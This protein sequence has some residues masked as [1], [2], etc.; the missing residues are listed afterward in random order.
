M[1]KLGVRDAIIAVVL[2]AV[3]AAATVV[4]ALAESGSSGASSQPP[5]KA[6]QAAGPAACAT[7][8]PSGPLQETPTKTPPPPT[9]TA[10][11]TKTPLPTQTAGPTKTPTNTP[12]NT[13]TDTPTNTPT[14]TPTNTPTDTPTNTPTDT[15][16]NTPTD[17][18]TNTPT[19]TPT[20]TPT[21]TPTPV[22]PGKATGGGTV[23]SP[24]GFASFGFNVQRK[25]N[26]SITGHLTYVDNDAGINLK[27]VEIDS[28]VIVGNT[29]TFTGTC[30]LNRD[31]CTFRVQVTDN[32]EPGTTDSFTIEINGGAAQGGTLRSGNIQIFT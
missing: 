21:P 9:Q 15:P 29:A 28:L 31:P 14:D 7:Q 13:P 27:S 19:N 22:P 24:C 11:P 12:T 10:G 26:G 32:G 6:A 20:K 2:A 18:P 4:S 5:D 16:T 1:S 8:G 25:S 30:T 23:P 17:T 3:V